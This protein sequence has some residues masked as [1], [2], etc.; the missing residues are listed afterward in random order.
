M[1]QIN[2]D[3]N[4]GQFGDEKALKLADTRAIVRMLITH[5][6]GSVNRQAAREL[7]E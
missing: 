3:L 2:Q 5:S 7:A 6:D 4:E 1:L